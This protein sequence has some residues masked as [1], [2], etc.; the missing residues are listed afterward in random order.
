MSYLAT[1]QQMQKV[2]QKELFVGLISG[3]MITQGRLLY[4][5]L[6]M[7]MRVVVNAFTKMLLKMFCSVVPLILC[8]C[9]LMKRM[10]TIGQ[11][12]Q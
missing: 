10:T 1:L 2:M 8:D 3:L 7:P 5:L 4:M 6:F 9:S 11:Y 12:P